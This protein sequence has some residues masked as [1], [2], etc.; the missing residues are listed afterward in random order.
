ME[1]DRLAARR[2][3][4][5]HQMLM[6]LDAIHADPLCMST[7]QA[8]SDG[9]PD[10][11][12]S[13]GSK[14]VIIDHVLRFFHPIAASLG[15]RDP[16]HTPVYKRNTQPCLPCSASRL[17][18]QIPRSC[19]PHININTLHASFQCSL[20]PGPQYLCERCKKAGTLDAC[21]VRSVHVHEPLPPLTS[22]FRAY[23]VAEI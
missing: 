22:I 23:P 16:T 4:E 8:I 18:V 3:L 21:R 14:R 10:T 1:Q 2:V 6:A 12:D 13:L 20:L 9:R 5:F 19:M 17:K 7:L 15:L 11:R